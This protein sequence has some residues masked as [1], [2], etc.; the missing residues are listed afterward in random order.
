MKKIF[1]LSELNKKPSKKFTKRK[2]ENDYNFSEENLSFQYDKK[3]FHKKLRHACKKAII[4][5][6]ESD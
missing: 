6:I 3:N 5:S 2:K 4:D 1:L